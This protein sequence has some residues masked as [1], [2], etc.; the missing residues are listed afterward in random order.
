MTMAA[1]RFEKAENDEKTMG[2]PWENHEKTMGKRG[3][4][5]ENPW[6]FDGFRVLDPN[7]E[8]QFMYESM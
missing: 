8:F 7:C 6:E 1:W 4:K 3:K 5:W 2:K